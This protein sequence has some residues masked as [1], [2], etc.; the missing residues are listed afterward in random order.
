MA[1]IKEVAKLAGVSYQAVSAVLNGNLAKASPATREKIFHSAA[2][3]NYRPN[4]SARSLV[5]GKSGM[6]GIV[7]Q[8]IRPPYFS[9][10]TWELQS[11]A[12]KRGLQT[13]MMESDWTEP[14]TLECIC[15]LYATPVDGI[16]FLGE[17]SRRSL[18]QA[19]IPDDYPLLLIDDA[20]NGCN[21]VGFDY[22]PGMEEAF[23]L[24]LDSGHKRLAFVHDPIQQMKFDAYRQ[25]CRKYDVPLREFRYLSPT[26][27]GEDA[28]I[29]CGHE[30][31]RA[32]AELDAIIVASDY[33]ASLLFQG[34]AAENV[35]I[36]E[37]LSMV[38]IDNTLLS[39][40]STPQ[41]SSISLDRRELAETAFA[42]LTARIAGQPDLD[43][44]QAIPTT[45]IRRSSVPLRKAARKEKYA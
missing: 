45:L 37:D 23:R 21:S 20:D 19:G 18:K 24:L 26:A 17:V 28:V 35:R 1:T 9:D 38:A 6:V 30:V 3:L 31:A 25:C 12:A 27:A 11:A 14:R 41:L 13:V 36:P 5:S 22:L 43:G 10:L 33:D 16:V 40:I 39:R 4:R 15:Q 34:F 7:I 44:H 8:D 42:R 32:A 29:S 2:R